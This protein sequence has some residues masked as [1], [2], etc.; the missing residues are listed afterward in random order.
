MN[1]GGL[2]WF[3]DGFRCGVPLFIVICVI[4]NIKIVKNRC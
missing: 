2:F 3:F 4:Y 1:H